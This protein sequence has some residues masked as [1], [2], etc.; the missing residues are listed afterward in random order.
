[1]AAVLATAASA[2]SSLSGIYKASISGLP[3]GLSGT[4]FLLIKD[5]KSFQVARGNALAV[6]G[7][8]TIAGSKITFRDTAGPLRCPPTQA[9]VY[10]F[11]LSK[12]TLALKRVND[13]CLGRSLIL[14]SKPFTKVA[15]S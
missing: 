9:G 8:V 3:Q 15:G 5:N 10:T 6:Q 12:K 4:W 1:M 13:P 7:K 11:K 14:G 2:A